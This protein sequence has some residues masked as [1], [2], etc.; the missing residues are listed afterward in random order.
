M[1]GRFVSLVTGMEG[2]C[3]EGLVGMGMP[4]QRLS[5]VFLGPPHSVAGG[6]RAGGVVAGCGATYVRSYL[7]L[8]LFLMSCTVSPAVIVMASVHAHFQA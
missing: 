8:L 3:P 1:Q 5:S 2:E 7:L 6:V 4:Y